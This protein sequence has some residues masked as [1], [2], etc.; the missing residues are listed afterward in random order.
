MSYYFMTNVVYIVIKD[1]YFFSLVCLVNFRFHCTF[2]YIVFDK[3]VHYYISRL[4]YCFF[5]IQLKARNII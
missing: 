5:S 1:F 3:I 2:S 4:I